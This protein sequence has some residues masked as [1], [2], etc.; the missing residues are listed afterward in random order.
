MSD[1]L[2]EAAREACTALM[3]F[4]GCDTNE[5]EPR[6][7]DEWPPMTERVKDW[8]GWEDFRAAIQ[9]FDHLREALAI[10]PEAPITH[11]LTVHACE[12]C[13]E[14]KSHVRALPDPLTPPSCSG[15]YDV[16]H[17]RRAMATVVYDL[18]PVRR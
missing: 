9:A 14:T 8:F 3:P 11:V 2:R 5:G 10:E 7:D 13:G 15:T 1:L 17:A 4:A 6:R 12:R 18:V 16:P